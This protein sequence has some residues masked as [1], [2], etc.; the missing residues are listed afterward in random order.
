MDETV[1]TQET[2]QEAEVKETKTFTQEEVN[3]IVSERVKKERA[4]YEGFDDL[5]A[6]AAKFDEMEE[7]NKTELQKATERAAE[8]EAKIK[9]MTEAESLRAMRAK[10][11]GE[12]GVPVEML[13]ETT[14]EA[15]AD[16]AKAILKFA[17]KDRYPNVLDGGEAKRTGKLS[18]S[19][20]FADWMKANMT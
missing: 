9:E 17:G 16:Q 5:K 4:K 18:T 1:K 13:T 2:T 8:L 6:K 7:A 14:E 12:T 11:A 20:Q 3:A 15:L 19:E 10:V